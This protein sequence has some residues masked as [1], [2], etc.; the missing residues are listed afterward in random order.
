M[1]IASLTVATLKQI[2]QLVEQKETL[3]AQVAQIDA[4]L[5]KF[6]TGEPAVQAKATPAPKPIRPAKAKRAARGAVKAAIVELLKGAGASGI[7]VRDIS[8]KLG[9]NYNRVFTWF[10][11]TGSQIK[12]IKKVAP[13]QYTWVTAP[14]VA[15]KPVAKV[16]SKPAAKPAP[17]AKPATLAK[18]S[19]QKA[20]A[21]QPAVTKEGVVGLIKSSG[22]AGITVK[23][24]AG[25]LGVDPQAIF[26]WFNATGKKVEEIK[27]VAPAT[28]AWAA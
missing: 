21:K 10:Y 27:K 14:V 7:T 3:Q 1:N 26:R 6:G 28:Y 20:P 11:T 22:K 24:I 18:P 25:K 19:A 17:V 4:Q 12:E 5:N 8:A 13:G 2:A 16:A 23:A 15:A 9:V